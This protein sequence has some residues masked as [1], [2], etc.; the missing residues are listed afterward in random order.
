MLVI[1]L[2]LESGLAFL[3]LGVHTDLARVLLGHGGDGERVAGASVLNLVL[4]SMGEE[5]VVA[6][7]FHVGVG[8]GD[9]ALEDGVLAL[10]S[11][12]I[13]QLGGQ[14]YQPWS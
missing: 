3:A 13:A 5:H 1:T 2:H 6:E 4:G 9:T 11:N 12:H 7:P 8:W 14:P 10:R